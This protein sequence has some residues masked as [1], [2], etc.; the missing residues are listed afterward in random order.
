MKTVHQDIVGITLSAKWKAFDA[1]VFFQGVAKRDFAFTGNSSSV[2]RGP[3][4]GPMHSN[5][6][7]EHLDYWRD[8][9]SALGANPNAYFP[10]PY[11]QYYAQN[12]KN[13]DYPTDHLL[14]NASYIRLKNLQLGYSVPKNI[15]QKVRLKN[16]RVYVSGENL[17]TITDLMFFDPEA[18]GGR[19]Y[20]A[21]DAYP[22]SKT[23][24]VGVNL[25]F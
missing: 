4:N 5:V 20:G 11:G 17:L 13:Y 16:A 9:T 21:G 19:W 15:A 18:L 2:F 22:L 10:A 8:E 12:Q 14:Q 24:S 25:N 6:R 23:W 3:A 7:D 1:S